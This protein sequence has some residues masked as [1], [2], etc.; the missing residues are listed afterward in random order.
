MK[1]G[2]EEVIKTLA[3]VFAVSLFVFFLLFSGYT[4]AA[5][6]EDEASITIDC[7]E[8]DFDVFGTSWK[9]YRVGGCNGGEGIVISDE[10]RGSGVLFEDMSVSQL[11]KDADVLA[12]YADKN[13]IAALQSI[14]AGE[15]QR[16]VFRGLSSGLYLVTGEDIKT[17]GAAYHIVPMLIGLNEE[18]GYVEDVVS[19]PKYYTEEIPEKYMLDYSVHKVWKGDE[20]ALGSRPKSVKIEIMRDDDLWKTVILQESNNWAYEWT[21]EPKYEWT[22]REVDIPGEYTVSYTKNQTSFTVENT[23][24]EPPSVPSTPVPNTGI[25]LAISCGGIILAAIIAYVMNLGRCQEKTDK[26]E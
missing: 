19:Y 24:K 18:N 23:Y 21:S 16:I 14:A 17:Q 7:S 15:D 10:F 22:V 2:K 8:N 20:N 6:T 12:E 5:Y 3:S 9:I 25:S 26:K 1:T 11:Q 13:K 4:A